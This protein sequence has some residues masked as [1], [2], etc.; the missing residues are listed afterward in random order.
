MYS[1]DELQRLQKCLNHFTLST[2]DAYDKSGQLYW[3]YC[4]EGKPRKWSQFV[5]G[6]KLPHKIVGIGD[7]PSEALD[8]IYVRWKELSGIFDEADPTE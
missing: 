7:T 8:E 3:K 1:H 5:D 4:L 6:R 2:L